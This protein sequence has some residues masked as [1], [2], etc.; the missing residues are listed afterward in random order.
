[1][2]HKVLLGVAPT[3]RD[4]MSFRWS[5]A[6]EYKEM[7][8]KKLD[9]LGI[10][11]ITLDDVCEDGLLITN[12]D[13]EAAK[14]KFK[15]L[16]INAVFFPFCDFGTE[17]AVCQLAASLRLPTLFWGPVD[18]DGQG[19]DGDA[20][21]GLVAAGKVMHW[22]N[23]PFTFIPTCSIDDAM[24]E[25]GLRTFIAAANIVKEFK[26]MR[27]LQVG[28]RPESFWSVICNEG[29]LISKTGIKVFPITIS[30][31]L[32]RARK[33]EKEAKLDVTHVVDELYSRC[34]VM[35]NRDV[36]EKSAALKLALRAYMDE[37]LSTCCAFQCWYALQAEY[38]IW[39]CAAGALLA[40]EGLP[41]VCETDIHGAITTVMTTAAAMGK[42]YPLFGEWCFRHPK[43]KA[44]EFV[45]HCGISPICLFPE[46]PVLRT[47][48]YA[49]CENW[50]GHISARAAGDTGDRISFTRFEADEKG[51]YNIL[52]GYGKALNEPD[53]VSR[54]ANYWLEVPDIFELENK[55]VKGSYI[56]HSA[57]IRGNV[58]PAIY[59]ALPYINVNPDFVYE[60]QKREV[61]RFL[62]TP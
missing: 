19:V 51:Q 56:H 44:A 46:K 62:F 14:K 3:H 30:E 20:Q 21:C 13:I 45:A 17:G 39:P 8:Y 50:G 49:G 15:S 52:L 2:D 60:E 57:Y 47:R 53:L 31:V 9:E 29:E 22:F 35:V 16:E 37:T 59:E 4:D 25:K 34:N 43:Y 7:V 42:E 33:F 10:T 32:Q 18:V 55:V 26:R 24:F 58:L 61:E 28:P 40:E 23:Q 41:V 36:V 54:G 11:Y 6:V 5:R 1:M 48:P 27:I 12:Q 38:G